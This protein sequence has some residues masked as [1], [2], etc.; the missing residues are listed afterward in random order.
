MQVQEKTE[1]DG[2]AL[3]MCHDAEMISMKPAW[4]AISRVEFSV[5]TNLLHQNCKSVNQ[6]DLTLTWVSNWYTS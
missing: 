6:I 1:G 5:R 3:M 2:A 4:S